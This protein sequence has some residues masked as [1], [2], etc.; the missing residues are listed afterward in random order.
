MVRKSHIKMKVVICA[1]SSPHGFP[2]GVLLCGS[3]AATLEELLKCDDPTGKTAL[4]HIL[5]EGTEGRYI[6]TLPRHHPRL[7]EVVLSDG[8]FAGVEDSCPMVIDIPDEKYVIQRVGNLE[9][10]CDPIT[11][12]QI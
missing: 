9:F 11:G 8:I 12:N 10:I 6:V 1:G 7:V 5:F 4:E 3:A 2:N